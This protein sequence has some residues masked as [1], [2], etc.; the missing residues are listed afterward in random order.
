[1]SFERRSPWNPT[2]ALRPTGGSEG[3]PSFGLND[4]CDAHAFN[5]VPSTLKCSDDT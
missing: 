1:M 2:S 3:G 5:R 4:L